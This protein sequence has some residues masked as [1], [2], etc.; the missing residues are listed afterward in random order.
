MAEHIKDKNLDQDVYNADI[1]AGVLASA[2][3]VAYFGSA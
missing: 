3:N 2:A 1:N